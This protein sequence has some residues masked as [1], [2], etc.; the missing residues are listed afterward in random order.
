MVSNLYVRQANLNVIL[1]SQVVQIEEQWPV[2]VKDWVR[3][4][5]HVQ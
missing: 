3:L 1:A 4:R 5:A 2:D